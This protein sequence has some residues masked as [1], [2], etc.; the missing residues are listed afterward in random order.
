MWKANLKKANNFRNFKYNAIFRHKTPYTITG[1]PQT[2]LCDQVIVGFPF[3][4]HYDLQPNTFVSYIGTFEGAW[5]F[6]LEL[7]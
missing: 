2:S 3:T 7:K 5:G 1:R 4:R 6:H